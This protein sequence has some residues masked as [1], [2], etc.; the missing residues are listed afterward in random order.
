MGLFCKGIAAIATYPIVTI[1]VR[2]QANKRKGE[3]GIFRQVA[4]IVRELGFRGLFL[5]LTT[6]LLQTTLNSAF[7]MMTYEK[8]REVIRTL[9]EIYF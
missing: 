3:G 2:V 6:K 9:L 8:T 5:G 7:L 4:G 1:R